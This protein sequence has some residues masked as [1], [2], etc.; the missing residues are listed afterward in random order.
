MEP[1]ISEADA[2]QTSRF[3]ESY[4]GVFSSPTIRLWKRLAEH[5]ETPSRPRETDEWSWAVLGRIYRSDVS[6]TDLDLVS[7]L[8]EREQ[9]LVRGE[10]D[11]PEHPYSTRE[12]N[13][14]DF[15]KFMKAHGMGKTLPNASKTAGEA[16][17]SMPETPG[18]LREESS[19]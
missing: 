15:E 9:F 3:I 8:P 19:P 5:Y 10:Y 16:V 1:V 17:G 14:R 18:L 12:E 11:A 2:L 13:V 4:P 7:V 6:P